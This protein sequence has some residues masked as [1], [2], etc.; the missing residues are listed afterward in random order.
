[1]VKKKY[2]IFLASFLVAMGFMS[3]RVWLLYAQKDSYYFHVVIKSSAEDMAKLYFDT[4]SGV[5]EKESVG[6]RIKSDQRFHHYWFQLPQGE[7]RH[8]RFDPL[9]VA[10]T[11][12]VATMEII[13]A[14]DNS[15]R[16]VDFHQLKA[17][18]Q[19]RSIEI[20]DR[21]ATIVTVENAN[22]PQISVPFDF[23]SFRSSYSDRAFFSICAMIALEFIVLI[24]FVS[25]LLWICFRWPDESLWTLMVLA[26]VVLGWRYWILYQ[27]TTISYLQVSLHSTVESTAQLFYDAGRGFNEVDSTSINIKPDEG[28][29]D[30]LFRLPR[31]TLFA[32]RFDPFTTGGTMRIENMKIMDGLGH[33]LQAVDLRQWH[34]TNQILELSYSQDSLNII[35][36]KKAVDPQMV[37]EFSFPLKLNRDR[38]FITTSLVGRALFELAVIGIVVLL[39]FVAIE[40][41][42]SVHRGPI[43]IKLWISSILYL[44]I[45]LLLFYI[46]AEGAWWHTVKFIKNLLA[47]RTYNF[48]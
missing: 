14:F 26:V 8:L 17:L 37:I 36:E 15:R 5:S 9:T 41:T 27:Q 24:S 46:F 34:P 3:W 1:M 7:I 22:D 11:L 4:G 19:I 48:S 39:I 16:A 25:V 10:G 42:Q 21:K 32:L 23:S 30:Y 28:R 40:K 2:I 29:R 6:A 12:T 20:H 18:H 44:L 13:D 43:R 31:A 47:N 33:H 35:T 38:F 45:C